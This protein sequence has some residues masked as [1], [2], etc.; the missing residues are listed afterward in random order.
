VYQSHDDRVPQTNA[1]ARFELA[2]HKS[3]RQIA[4][5]A[6]EIAEAITFWLDG[7]D[8]IG[9]MSESLRMLCGNQKG[10]ESGDSR[11]PRSPVS[12]IF[13]Q[14]QVMNSLRDLS[15]HAI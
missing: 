3:L 8:Y 13:E 10:R 14:T 1:H 12:V 15:L 6:H 4:W 9:V 5:Q 7:E 11:S 2:I